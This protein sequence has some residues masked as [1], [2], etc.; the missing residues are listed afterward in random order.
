MLALKNT[1]NM[2]GALISGDYWDLDELCTAIYQLTG[3]EGRYLDWQGA[4][5]RLLGVSYE[6]R[7]AYQGDRHID[8]VANG[9]HKEVMKAH[10]F[11]ASENNIYYSTEILW[12]ELVFSFIAINDFIKLHKK[13]EKKT[14]YDVSI[15]TARKFQSIIA[16]GLKENMPEADYQTILTTN[17]NVEEYAI[18]YIDMLNLTYIEM[19]KEQ[20]IQSFPSIAKNIVLENNEYAAV[21]RKVMSEA[22][23]SKSAI[24]QLKFNLEY[25]EN[26]EW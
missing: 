23:S 10:D 1:E 2:T 15:V 6:L 21:K 11:V 16:D 14:D 9:L 22:N 20:R 4:R 25:P 19:T 12:P 26:I 13:Y 7:H 8:T 17:T 3:E 24:H 5:M 18:Q